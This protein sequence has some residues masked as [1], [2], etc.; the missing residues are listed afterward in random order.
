[1]GNYYSIRRA[2]ASALVYPGDGPKKSC[3][4][5]TMVEYCSG[6]GVATEYCRMFAG[7]DTVKID[8]RALLKL[9][10]AKVE[11]I[12][13]AYKH[14]LNGDFRDNR[15]VYYVSEDGSPLNW[16]GFNGK[17]NEGINAPYLVC[18]V[19]TAQAWADYEASQAT[20]PPTEA[21]DPVVPA[22]DPGVD[23]PV[24]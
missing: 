1:M 7:V 2:S 24:A 8:S 19:H 3:T 4:K 5:H 15:Y 6:G 18:P 20:E 17:A 16:H 14:G 23:V 9:T 10:P 13:S 21:P 11:Q 22:P 12:N